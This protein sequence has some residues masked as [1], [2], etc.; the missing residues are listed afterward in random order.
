[1]PVRTSASTAWGPRL[2]VAVVAG[3]S[4]YDLCQVAVSWEPYW[5]PRLVL[6]YAAALVVAAVVGAVCALDVRI[7]WGLLA[8]TAVAAVA[9]KL[10]RFDL[11]WH[12]VCLPRALFLLLAAV[13]IARA[14]A[15]RSSHAVGPGVGL[16]S[17]AAA[18]FAIYVEPITAVPVV[19]VVAGL[20]LVAAAFEP[21]WLQRS[22]TVAGLLIPLV[23]VLVV[24]QRH[25]QPPRP[26]LH[27]AVAAPAAA[28]RPNVI[29][30]VLDTVSAHH[31]A[32]Y[33]YERVTTPGLDA[34]V[35]DHA[36]RYTEVH[37]VSS[38]TLPSHGSMFTGLYPSEHGADYPRP[39]GQDGD[40][41]GRNTAVRLGLWPAEPLRA[42][43]PTLAERLAAA[44]YQTGAVIGNCGWLN[45]EFGVDRGFE[46]YDDRDA[47]SSMLLLQLAGF[48]ESLN[49][50]SSR[51]GE[52][53]TDL[54]MRW[55]DAPGRRRPFFLFMN[56]MDAHAPYEPPPPYDRTFQTALP[57]QP[58][59]SRLYDEE[60]RYL[61]AQV[62]RFLH[63]LEARSLLDDSV[64]IITADHGEAFGEHGFWKHDQA[65]YE[66][67]IRVP[68]YVKS[69]GPSRPGVSDRALTGPDLYRLMLNEV[70]LPAAEPSSASPIVAEW[71]QPDAMTAA[72][73]TRR[74][75]TPVPLDR[76]LLVWFDAGL[77]WIVSS[78]GAVEAYDLHADPG[79]TH[80]VDLAA[81]R[82]EQARA[83]ARDWWNAHPPVKRE[84]RASRTLDPAVVERLRN[85]GYAH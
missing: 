19:A 78:K 40:A 16:G 9:P 74:D 37:S 3:W 85:L 61:D 5:V 82:V 2:F 34:F 56:Y 14:V 36:V 83:R 80:P 42:D 59:N 76:D 44:G 45:H 4:V 31:L 53:I 57:G 43:V 52:A 11:A 54:A 84:R 81:E 55:L 38:W 32:P 29:L 1:M 51:R 50:G 63:A 25:T 77:K 66:E 30:I 15:R 71:Y 20:V 7:L 6:G 72:A 22:T 69:A 73:I 12:L 70:G 79:E 26:E 13:A 65:L 27:L 60:L 64:V 75:G 48:Y 21:A 23:V 62:T 47:F 24:A 18:V 68:L 35:R 49:K 67:L 8:A 39:A 10:V 17:I 28:S 33:G 58:Q 41:I 46:H